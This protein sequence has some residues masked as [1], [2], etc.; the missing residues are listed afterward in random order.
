MILQQLQK[1]KKL[2]RK[3]KAK[4]GGDFFRDE[5]HKIHDTKDAG[6]AKWMVSLS[7][8]CRKY[9]KLLKKK[10]EEERLIE[11][12][13]HAPVLKY[14]NLDMVNNFSKEHAKKLVSLGG[15]LNLTSSHIQ[16]LGDATPIGESPQKSAFQGKTRNCDLYQELQLKNQIQDSEMIKGFCKSGQ[17]R[18]QSRKGSATDV[19]VMS[20]N[21]SRTMSNESH[22][23]GKS[24]S[25]SECNSIG[26]GKSRLQSPTL[27]PRGK[28]PGSRG[29]RN[30]PQSTH[31]SGN[32]FGEVN[33]IFEGKA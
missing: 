21:R 18:P 13:K 10:L 12:D 27:S 9:Q 16:S 30:K 23:P 17:S 32:S 24:R 31:S 15:M 14:R 11:M 19:N 20:R 33:F 25:M 3:E 28:S 2:S 7:E 5:L 6:K 8:E 22:G 26:K 4:T 1:N 29:H